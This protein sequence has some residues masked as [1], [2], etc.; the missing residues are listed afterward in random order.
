MEALRE[1]YLDAQELDDQN[2]IDTVDALIQEIR[3]LPQTAYTLDPSSNDLFVD[4]DIIERS[5]TV[6]VQSFLNSPEVCIPHYTLAF[7]ACFFPA[8]QK[9]MHLRVVNHRVQT[10]LT[11]LKA[12]IIGQF[13]LVKAIVT[14]VGSVRPF[15]ESVEHECQRCGRSFTEH[16]LNG[17]YKP[18]QKCQ[19]SGCNSRAFVPKICS[20]G[21]SIKNFQ[22]L[23]SIAGCTHLL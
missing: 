21:T 12:C 23:R 15:M 9:R 6:P 14:R 13:V 3:G 8:I 10:H 1:L 5:R 19:T 11:E 17:E 16:K 22:R 2:V 18:P 7:H 4:F 20:P